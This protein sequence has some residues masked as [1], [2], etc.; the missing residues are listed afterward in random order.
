MSILE[1]PS[2]ER[3]RRLRQR[4]MVDRLDE[5]RELRG[6]AETMSQPA[7]AKALA[8]T[9]PAVNVA[10]KRARTVPDVPEGFSGASPYEIAQRYAAGLMSREQLIDELGRF[11]YA[12]TPETDGLD[13]L[14][15]EV[16]NTV[17]E[18]GRAWDHELIDEETYEAIQDAI[19]VHESVFASS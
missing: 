2:V 7:I 4:Q 15:L 3:V 12:P 18:V 9:Q 10:L 17:G 1:A 16:P 14:V 19:D 5:L 8:I 11:P 13:W 6:L